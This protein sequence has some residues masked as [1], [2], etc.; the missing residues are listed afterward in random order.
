MAGPER[1]YTAALEHLQ[2][3]L[4]DKEAR[5]ER[6]RNLPWQVKVATIERVRDTCRIARRSMRKRRE[7]PDG[8]QT[9]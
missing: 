2:R 9:T 8:K 3:V 6:N 4:L 5:R 7:A 1:D